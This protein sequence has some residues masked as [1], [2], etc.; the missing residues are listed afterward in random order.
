MTVFQLS[1]ELIDTNSGR[2]QF[3]VMTLLA[4]LREERLRDLIE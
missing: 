3:R 1:I 2:A 4:V